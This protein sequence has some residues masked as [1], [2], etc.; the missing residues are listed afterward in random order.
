M[1]PVAREDGY[2]S[3]C[4]PKA[5]LNSLA[6]RTVRLPKLVMMLKPHRSQASLP[7]SSNTTLRAIHE[8][9]GDI[10]SS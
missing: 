5:G 8:L 7:S 9:R 2:P 1:L 3:Y 4:T 6:R 10:P